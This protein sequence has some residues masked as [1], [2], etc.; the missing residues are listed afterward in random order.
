MKR[1]RE[2]IPT[3]GGAR[4]RCVIGPPSAYSVLTPT[5]RRFEEKV[6]VETSRQQRCRE[7]GFAG[8]RTGCRSRRPIAAV[9]EPLVDASEDWMRK[10]SRVGRA[11]DDYVRDN[12]WQ[13]VGAVALL[14]VALGFVLSRRC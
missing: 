11:A 7:E 12:P 14:G 1:P 2:P 10:G 8:G 5:A 6:H 4:G 3:R 9:M 13:A